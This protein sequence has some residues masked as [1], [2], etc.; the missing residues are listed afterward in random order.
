MR[1]RPICPDP[2]RHTRWVIATATHRNMDFTTGCPAGHPE[3]HKLRSPTVTRQ[4]NRIECPSFGL[5]SPDLTYP[6]KTSGT[7]QYGICKTC[8]TQYGM[9]RT[10]MHRVRD[11]SV[12]GCIVQGAHRPW[13]ALSMG[14]FVHWT[15]RPRDESFKNFRLRTSCTV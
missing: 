12:K 2:G 14:R 3:K 1:P 9:D 13:D 11:A 4:M 6:K 8:K 15:V 10:S 7:T 5:Y